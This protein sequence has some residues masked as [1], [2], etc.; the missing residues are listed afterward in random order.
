MCLHYFFFIPGFSDKFRPLIYIHIIFQ[1]AKLY[2]VEWHT[3]SVCRSVKVL[4]KS[5]NLSLFG[6][7]KNSCA[8]SHLLSADWVTILTVLWNRACGICG[9]CWCRKYIS[10]CDC[11][12]AHIRS[13]CQMS[14]LYRKWTQ[15]ESQ[16]T[17]HFPTSMIH[18]FL[19]NPQEWNM[20]CC[21]YPFLD[22]VY[23]ITL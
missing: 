21:S 1:L 13:N 8:L 5:D 19:H 18:S 2:H 11:L 10:S 14:I 15:F 4:E 20:G 7:Y 6:K 9:W 16:Q 12:N 22:L 17:P 3:N 23:C